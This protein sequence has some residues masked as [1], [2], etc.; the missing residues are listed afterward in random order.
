M[1]CIHAPIERSNSKKNFQ[2]FDMDRMNQSSPMVY[3][4]W[5]FILIEIMWPASQSHFHPLLISMK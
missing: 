3:F 2:L 1:S 5:A 4:D